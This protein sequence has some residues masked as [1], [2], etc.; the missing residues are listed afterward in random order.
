MN[1]QPG[2]SGNLLLTGG[3]GLGK[4]FLS[5]AIAREVSGKGFSV[6]Y[7]TAGHIFERFNAFAHYIHAEHQHG[8]ADHDRTDV[9]S[10]FAL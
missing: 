3:T 1:F 9:A 4:T 10:A 8:K 6:V 7:D 5:A 2:V